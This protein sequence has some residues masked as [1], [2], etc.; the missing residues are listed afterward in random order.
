MKAS[1]GAVEHLLLVPVDDLP[2]ALADLHVRGLRVAGADGDAPLAARSADLRG[3]IALVIG[4]EGQGLG[5]AVRRRVDFLVRI[6]MRG[7][8]RVAQ[9]RGRRVGAPVRGARSAGPGRELTAVPLP[10][11]RPSATDRSRPRRTRRPPRS[12]SRRPSD[13]RRGRRSQR[14]ETTA[15]QA[16]EEPAP[17]EDA[18]PTRRA[19]RKKAEPVEASDVA[20]AGPCRRARRPRSRSA[21]VGPR[22]QRP[23]TPTP[24]SCRAARLQAPPAWWMTHDRPHRPRRAL[25]SHARSRVLGPGSRRRIDP[26]R[27]YRLPRRRPDPRVRPRRLPTSASSRTPP[28]ACPRSSPR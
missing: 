28:A 2:G 19:T 9:R 1:A 23:T 12:T 25:R 5:P 16:A 17:I 27:T 6:P 7:T 10:H 26:R 24:T 22:R 14:C 4:S 21:A 13:A 8:C 20:S 11:R 18:P 15:L 3:P